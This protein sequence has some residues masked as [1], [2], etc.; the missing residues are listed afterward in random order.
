MKTNFTL[1]AFFTIALA[2]P[3]FTLGQQPAGI[4]LTEQKR[5]ELRKLADATL[6]APKLNTSPGPEYAIANLEYGMT[7][8]I[9]RTPGD[10]IREQP[11]IPQHAV[12]QMRRG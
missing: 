1:W 2:L 11:S 4:V 7:I 5:Q 8:G 3:G 12:E 6:E 9:E 10:E